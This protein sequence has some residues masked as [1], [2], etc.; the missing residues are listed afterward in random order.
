MLNFCAIVQRQ[1]W[2]NNKDSNLYH[3]VCAYVS[4]AALSLFCR[5]LFGKHQETVV[6]L[7]KFLKVQA[8]W[9]QAFLE[10]ILVKIKRPTRNGDLKTWI[11]VKMKFLN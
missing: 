7:T 1:H 9:L 2:T 8:K 6:L 11:L 5:W 4:S 10:Q 3:R